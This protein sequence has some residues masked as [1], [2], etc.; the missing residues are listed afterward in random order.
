MYMDKTYK[1]YLQKSKNKTVRKVHKNYAIIFFDDMKYNID[2]MKAKFNTHID[3]I[4]LPHK[5]T[6]VF[7]EV[8]IHDGSTD[9]ISVTSNSYVFNAEKIDPTIYSN[10]TKSFELNI[11][12]PILYDWIKIHKMDTK[13]VVFDW[14]HALSI[15]NGVFPP[16]A[17]S[18]LPSSTAYRK[19]QKVSYQTMNIHVYDVALF[20]MGGH[21]RLSGLIQMFSK[22]HRSGCKIFILTANSIANTSRKEFVKVIQVI[23]PHF[24]ESHLICSNQPGILL[25]KSAAIMANPTFCRFTGK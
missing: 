2:D 18:S 6:N 1:K 14:D 17:F 15:T 24:H 13:I 11:H 9:S 25:T 23:I 8:A 7:N 19:T 20:L 12:K 10:T 3:C 5:K 22:L 16:N 4:Y 21:T